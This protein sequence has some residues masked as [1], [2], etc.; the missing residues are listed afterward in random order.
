[1]ETNYYEE[2]LNKITEM[3]NDNQLDQATRLIKNELDMPYIPADVE[4]LLHELEKD[5]RSKKTSS[6]KLLSQE[7]IEEYLMGDP[8]MQL[9]AV[10]ALNHYH[11]RPFMGAIQH[12]FDGNP[13]LNLQSLLIETLID[14]MISDEVTVERDGQTITFI[15]RYAEKPAETD[16][17]NSAFKYLCEWYE[18]EDPSFLNLCHQCL[19][20]QCYLILPQ[21]YEEDDALHLALSI[22]KEVG[23]YFDDDSIFESLLEKTGLSNVPLMNLKKIEG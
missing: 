1:M 13:H 14:Q 19:I 7:D 2:I 21:A 16:G 10:E 8:S 5:V 17:Y 4:K 12:F 23:S 20:Q 6:L 11:A 18:N 3:I 9:Q 22:V 15:P